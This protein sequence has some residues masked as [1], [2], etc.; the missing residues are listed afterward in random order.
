MDQM[1]TAPEPNKLEFRYCGYQ[2]PLA[3]ALFFV[4]NSV[5]TVNLPWGQMGEPLTKYE[6]AP[7]LYIQ[8][9]R[10]LIHLWFAQ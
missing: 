8:N 4:Y 1:A 10:W 9:F 6:L 7:N 5:I 2:L 3:D